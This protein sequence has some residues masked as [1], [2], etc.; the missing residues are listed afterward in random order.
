MRRIKVNKEEYVDQYLKYM[1]QAG[2]IPNNI[3]TKPFIMS[4]PKLLPYSNL[5]LQ[6]LAMQP[7]PKEFFL[8]PFKLEDGKPIFFESK[9][10]N[11]SPVLLSDKGLYRKD[12]NYIIE[13]NY[14]LVQAGKQRDI[15]KNLFGR[16]YNCF[17]LPFN[18]HRYDAELW[19]FLKCIHEK[20]EFF[21]NIFTQEHKDRTEQYKLENQYKAMMR[22]Q[23]E[24]RPGL[25][26]NVV[27]A[28]PYGY[29]IK[30]MVMKDFGQHRYVLL[31]KGYI[32]GVIIWSD[33][34]LYPVVH[35]F[36]WKGAQ[37]LDGR[38]TKQN[39][40][41]AFFYVGVVLALNFIS[42]FPE[43][44]IINFG[45]C[46][47][48]THIRRTLDRLYPVQIYEITSCCPVQPNS[49][50]R[51]YVNEPV[52]GK[53]PW[54]MY[55]SRERKYSGANYIL[56]YNAYKI[57]KQYDEE[58]KLKLPTKVKTKNA[59]TKKQLK[60]DKKYLEVNIESTI[61]SI[62]KFF[63]GSFQNVIGACFRN[64]NKAD[65]DNVIKSNNL[66]YENPRKAKGSGE[67]TKRTRG[68]KVKR[69]RRKTRSL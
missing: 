67:P 23:N 22:I 47:K 4:L 11:S 55:W 63:S 20:K 8:P 58:R 26:G 2:V 15:Y 48:S 42:S 28:Y 6:G 1:E 57:A 69:R 33:S 56:R 50:E 21:K 40:G 68:R 7:W 65:E 38:V 35:T 29:N 25:I 10:E 46:Y 16:N 27:E 17:P 54:E 5:E 60:I 9:C 24:N 52:V 3:C 39:I 36:V 12:V 62:H 43:G 41:D 13:R 37:R 61:K 49:I 34:Y 19:F 32:L 51:E 18:D 31:Y 64:E 53:L 30:N 59:L 66:Y 44:T 14:S 45:G